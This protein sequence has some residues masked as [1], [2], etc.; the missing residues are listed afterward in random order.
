VD[1]ATDGGAARGLVPANCFRN[2][3]AVPTRL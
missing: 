2:G 3:D 1:G